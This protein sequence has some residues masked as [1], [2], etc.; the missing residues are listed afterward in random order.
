MSFC[1]QPR[2]V[3]SPREAP[4]DGFPRVGAKRKNT[5]ENTVWDGVVQWKYNESH[6]LIIFKCVGSYIEKYK[7]TGA[8]ILNN[9]FHLSQYTQ[10]STIHVNL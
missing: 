5:A 9:R 1:W 3:G 6:T 8:I 7:E 2:G 10:N 4:T